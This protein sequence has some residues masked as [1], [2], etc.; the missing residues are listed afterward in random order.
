MRLDG[1]LY[2]S[3]YTSLRTLYP[4][5]AVGGAIYVDDYGSYGGCRPDSQLGD[6]VLQCTLVL[7]CRC[8]TQL[9]KQRALLVTGMLR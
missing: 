1:D 6:R 8:W 2:D 7:V 3:T 4:L 5:L 9:M